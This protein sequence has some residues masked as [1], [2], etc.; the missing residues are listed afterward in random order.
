MQRV[1]REALAR[2]VGEESDGDATVRMRVSIS[3]RAIGDEGS[4]SPKRMATSMPTSPSGKASRAVDTVAAQAGRL[5]FYQLDD[6]S[7]IVR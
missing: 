1:E 2:P 7:R 4:G 5:G 3:S 6:T